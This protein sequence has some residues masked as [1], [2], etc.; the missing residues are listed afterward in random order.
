MLAA[1]RLG[2]ETVPVIVLAHLSDAQKKAFRIADNKLA[3]N[4][5][6]NDDL[7]RLELEELQALDFDLGLTGFGGEELDTLLTGTAD[8]E[9]GS[10]ADED[11]APEPPAEPV[12]RPGDLWCLGNHR[13]LC[14]N[15]TVLADVGRLLG[16]VAPHLMI[17]DP[18]TASITIRP[19]ATRFALPAPGLARSPMTIAPT[20]ARPGRC[21]RVRSLMS[22]TPRFMPGWSP[23]A[24]RCAASSS[25]P[26]SSGPSRGSRSGAAIITGNMSRASMRCAKVAPAIG[27]G[28]GIRPRSGRS[29]AAKMM[30]PRFTVPRSRSPACAGRSRTT[31]LKATACM[32]HFPVP[33]PP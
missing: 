19:G 4:A 27:K 2:L 6:W 10:E 15:A 12:S 18:P 11:A 25:A 23:K 5:G 9:G 8:G 22:G 14:G 1:R 3:L 29:P 30:A 28:R 7:L 20:G 26:R 33:A 31:R 16:G 24:W 32:S 13:L 21:S 17:T